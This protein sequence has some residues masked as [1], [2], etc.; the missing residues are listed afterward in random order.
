MVGTF[1]CTRCSAVNEIEVK[2]RNTKFQKEVHFE[3]LQFAVN[4]Y[5]CNTLNT[6]AIRRLGD[7][8]IYVKPDVNK[9]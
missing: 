6:I 4:C 7:H 1:I 5:E 2:V 3:K 8:Y 9:K